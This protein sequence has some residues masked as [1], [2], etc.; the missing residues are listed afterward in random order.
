MP[1]FEALYGTRCRYL[2]GLFEVCEFSLLGIVL[3]YE[4][5]KKIRVI[6]DRLKTTY[7]R[8]K[9]YADNRRKEL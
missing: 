8:K 1:R 3:V 2:V 9:Y 4:A 7:S 6:R 5:L